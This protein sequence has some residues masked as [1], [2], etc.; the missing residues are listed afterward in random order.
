LHSVSKLLLL[1]HHQV[2]VSLHHHHL[3]LLNSLHVSDRKTATHQ[4]LLMHHH[5]VLTRVKLSG[6][7]GLS[8]LVLLSILLHLRKSILLLN[9]ALLEFKLF[10]GGI[11]SLLFSFLDLVFQKSKLPRLDRQWIF[12]VVVG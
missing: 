10:N 12:L 8:R 9:H 1:N 2:L 3:L 5:G 4:C 7:H 11:V 6:V